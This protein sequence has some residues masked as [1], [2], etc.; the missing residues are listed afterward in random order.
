M[1]RA[2][3][4]VVTGGTKG[5]GLALVER[6]A[7]RGWRV[8][9]MARHQP[10]LA[11][12]AR[13]AA[14]STL[15]IVPLR[16]DITDPAAVGRLVRRLTADRRRVDLLIHNAGLL[17]RRAPLADWP[18]RTFEQVM[19]AN[20]T[21]PFDLTRRLLPRLRE[22]A[23]IA[24]VSSGVTHAP[25]EGWGAYEISKVAMERLAQVFALELAERRVASV[26]IQPGR[27]RTDMR[28]QAFPDEDPMTLPTADAVAGRMLAL[29]D[30]VT[31]ADSGT[32]LDAS[33]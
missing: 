27:M 24:F 4:A 11:R 13:H 25:R 12:L 2:R 18:R 32:S 6:L 15:A 14:E 26:I 22:G 17:G 19:A 31:L 29:L 16:G 21:A 3:T 5:L 20:V 23:T 7:N 9:T 33:A 1:T 10:A 8:Y 28:A 30:G